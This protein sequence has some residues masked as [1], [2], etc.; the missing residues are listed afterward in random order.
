MAAD[1]AANPA[2]GAPALTVAHVMR[3]P[4]TTVERDAHLAG[5]AYLMKHSG[6]SALVVVVDDERRTP[7]ALITDADITQAVADGRDLQNT[8]I[9][10]LHGSPPITVQVGTGIST[11]IRRMLT[12]NIHHLPVVDGDRLVGLVEM[13][14]L[15]RG[16]IADLPADAPG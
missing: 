7:V 14:D 3:P 15:C 10:D 13:S 5:A 16:L 2:A 6:S 8:R 11:A 4:T 9:G 1:M 12:E